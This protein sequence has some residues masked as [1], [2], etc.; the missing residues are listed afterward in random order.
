MRIAQLLTDNCSIKFM[1][2][3]NQIICAMRK[4]EIRHFKL[5]AARTNDEETRKDIALFDEIHR[6]REKYDEQKIAF[7]L[8]EDNK[9]AFYRL[10]NRLLE[11]VSK[12]LWM[13]HIEREAEGFGLYLY[14]LAKW[15][16][17]EKR[18]EVALYFLKKAE[19]QATQSENYD[20]LDLVY[21]LY[22]QFSV[23]TT[24]V[25][26]AEYIVL[27]KKNRQKMELL[28]EIDD[29]LASII[30][31]IR[32]SFNILKDQNLLQELQQ[33]VAIFTQENDISASKKL[34]FKIYD[35]LI[36]ILL[37]KNEFHS[38]ETYLLQTFEEF[39]KEKL[40]DKENHETKLNMLTYLV[41]TLYKNEKYELSLAYNDR[42]KSEMEE[43]HGLYL[44]K[45]RIFY[46]NALVNNYSFLDKEKAIVILLE[47]KDMI[48]KAENNFNRISVYL[49]LALMYF[50]THQFRKTLRY[51]N[52]LYAW[53]NYKKTD[54]G[55]RL[56]TEIFEVVARFENNEG[57]WLKQRIQK[58]RKTFSK[59]LKQVEYEQDTSFLNMM[60][61]ICTLSESENGE[62]E[63]AV[64]K[65]QFLQN[66][67]QN[68]VNPS[69]FD[70]V[71]WLQKS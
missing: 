64:V 14:S 63:I 43:F 68:T 30:Y 6:K 34:R 3:L 33:K 66:Y 22:I 39:S 9:N 25:N 45:Y 31:Q 41:N 52:E 12:S 37:Q 7:Q 44:E 48:Q 61:T 19:K 4:E 53:E 16:F 26:P 35:A 67:P 28:A 51:L 1:D 20:I 18:T 38:M 60:Q 21:H 47:M 46:Y 8:Y 5:Y 24:Q 58:L 71:A 40:F 10:K 69:I 23:E 2:I 49:N 42:L 15:H 59:R 70:Y 65:Q 54:E 13:Q 50:Y 27:R 11:E 62:R 29:L 57:E 17:K 55:L 32:T 56:Q 36:R